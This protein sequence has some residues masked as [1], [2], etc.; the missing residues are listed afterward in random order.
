MAREYFQGELHRHWSALRV[1]AKATSAYLRSNLGLATR[2]CAKALLT[3]PE[4][5]PKPFEHTLKVRQ[6]RRNVPW[7]C[8]EGVSSYTEIARK[9]HPPP[10]SEEFEKPFSKEHLSS[11]KFNILKRKSRIGGQKVSFLLSFKL[12]NKYNWLDDRMHFE[13]S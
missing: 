3:H 7:G 11:S 13:I 9:S 4:R 2:E 1:R 10:K 6:S 12:E 8:T 5:V